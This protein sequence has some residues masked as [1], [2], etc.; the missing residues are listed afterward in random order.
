M[1][2]PC[3][4]SK[5]R[6]IS[7]NTSLLN[8]RKLFLGSPL[9]CDRRAA[10]WP[11]TARRPGAAPSGHSRTRA[12]LG[13]AACGKGQPLGL[14]RARGTAWALRPGAVPSGPTWVSQNTDSLLEAAPE[15]DPEAAEAAALLRLSLPLDQV[16]EG[17]CVQCP[18]GGDIPAGPLLPLLPPSGAS[19]RLARP[20][21]RGHQGS[22]RHCPPIS[23]LSPG[24]GPVSQLAGKKERQFL[25]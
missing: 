2:T 10:V 13:G 12:G 5:F 20:R 23:Q 7:S 6:G 16:E 15:A 1:Y 3:Q 18:H 22:S 25:L 8:N 17:V 21:A 14:R 19:R 9:V 4:H 11:G 24:P